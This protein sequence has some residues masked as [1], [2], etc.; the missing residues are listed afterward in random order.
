MV[1]GCWTIVTLLFAVASARA[2]LL[3][4]GN[5]PFFQRDHRSLFGLLLQAIGIAIAANIRGSVPAPDEPWRLATAFLLAPL[6]AALASSGPLW[7]G[8]HLR[9][10]AVVT[11]DHALITS[12]PYSIVRHPLY[13][14]VLYLVAATG[15][16]RASGFRLIVG[17]L[18]YCAGTEIRVLIE[19]ALLS[20]RFPKALLDYK[21][22]VKAYIP[23]VR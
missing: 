4:R 23:L 5:E 21:R 19:E 11:E 22:R 10:Q 1:I 7:L 6:G 13:G 17:V 8:R 16:V 18:V 9:G 20:N 15:L 2:R 3:R 14:G 12:G